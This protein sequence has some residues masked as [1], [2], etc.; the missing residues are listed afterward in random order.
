[1]KVEVL[2]KKEKTCLPRGLGGLAEP[3][4]VEVSELPRCTARRAGKYHAIYEDAHPDKTCSRYARYVM[5]GVPLCKT[6]AA[7]VALNYVL[8]ETGS[9]AQG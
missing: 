7:E 2:L 4:L 1:M 3:Q 5:D 9:V 6:H 8:T